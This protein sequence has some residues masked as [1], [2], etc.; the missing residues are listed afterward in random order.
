[1]DSLTPHNS[2]FYSMFFKKILGLNI[3]VQYRLI[4]MYKVGL[5]HYFV[6]ILLPKL[7][8]EIFH[9]LNILK[10][11]LCCKKIST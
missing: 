5:L 7:I 4:G 8:S 9:D 11:E 2:F 1:M 10:I 6:N 3:T